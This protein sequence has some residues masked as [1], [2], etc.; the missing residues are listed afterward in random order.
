MQQSNT[1]PG[2]G[3]GQGRGLTIQTLDNPLEI[4]SARTQS[5]DTA[6]DL[7]AAYRAKGCKVELGFTSDEKRS[8]LSVYTLHYN[9]MAG[10]A[11]AKEVG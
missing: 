8:G 10:K 7:A 1:V 9:P 6:Y 5:L 11:P 3:V 2:V 4:M